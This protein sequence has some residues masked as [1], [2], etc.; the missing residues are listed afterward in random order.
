MMGELGYAILFY[1]FDASTMEKH[2]EFDM[3]MTAIFVLKQEWKN[4][5]KSHLQFLFHLT[6]EDNGI[7]S[8]AMF[9]GRILYYHGYLLTHQQLHDDGNCSEDGCC[10]NYLAY[11]NRKLLAHLIKSYQRFLEAVMNGNN[12]YN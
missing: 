12:G 7:L 8:I 11:A 3:N 6:G 9:P 2:M 10:L 5:K 1:N 4:K